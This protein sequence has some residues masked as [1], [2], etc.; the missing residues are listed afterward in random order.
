MNAYQREIQPASKEEFPDD[1]NG[2]ELWVQLTFSRKDWSTICLRWYKN[3]C[4]GQG[5]RLEDLQGPFLPHD[6]RSCQPKFPGPQGHVLNSCT[7][8]DSCTIVSMAKLNV[9]IR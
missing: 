1:K 7:K 9:V 4:L 8:C 2:R 5:G 3:F 6:S